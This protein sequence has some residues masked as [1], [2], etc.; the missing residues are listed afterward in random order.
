MVEA[1]V[2]G[3][4]G[5]R[6]YDF[7]LPLKTIKLKDDDFCMTMCQTCITNPRSVL[8]EACDAASKFQEFTFDEDSKSIQWTDDDDDKSP[9]CLDFKV[10]ED[11]NG[12]LGPLAYLEPSCT[13]SMFQQWEPI[14]EGND[15]KIRSAYAPRLFLQVNEYAKD[16]HVR[17]GD[18]TS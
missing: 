17:K 11:E 5:E 3:I 15:I 16:Q 1:G 10:L 2:V 14:F 18:G 8:I 6:A 9:Y 12:V 4:T 13:G 7:I